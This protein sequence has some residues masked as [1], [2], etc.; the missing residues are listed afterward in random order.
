MINFGGT[1]FTETFVGNIGY[2]DLLIIA[3]FFSAWIRNTSSPVSFPRA[4]DWGKGGRLL[5]RS[6]PRWVSIP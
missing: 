6:G 1:T 3:A 5:W 2:P 4:P